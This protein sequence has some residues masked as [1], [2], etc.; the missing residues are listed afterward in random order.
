MTPLTAISPIDGR[1]H[2][3]TKQLS[4][5]FSEEALI[6]Y[7]VKVEVEYFIALCELP[8]PQLKDIDHSVFSYL[9]AIYKNFTIVDAQAVKEIEKTTNHDVKAV[10]YLLKNKFDELGLEESKEFI[11]FGLTSQDI[12]NTAVPLSLKDAIEAEYLPEIEEIIAK[13][14]QLSQDW[15][16]VPLLARTHGQPASPTRLGKE[17]EVFITRLESQLDLLN[18]VP[19]AAKFGGATGNFNAHKIAYP[20]ID[21]KEFGTNFV[22]EKLGLHH[23]FPTTQI[24]HYDH[25]AALFD[26]LKRINNILIDLDRDIWTYVSMDYF[27]QKIKKGEIGSSAMPHKVNPIDFENSEGNLGIANAIFEHLSSKLPISRL[28]RDLT[29]S[30]VLRNIGVP[31]GHTS[32][33]FKSTLKGLG[34]L[35]LNEEK[36]NADLEANWAVVAEAIQTI[37]RREG[38]K[39]P[40]ETLKGLT[41]TNEKINKKSIADFIETLE[42]SEAV[43][44]ELKKITPQNYTGI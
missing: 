2:S 29:D 32:I 39:N 12:N 27:K 26:T 35:L 14:T 7:R 20:N 33:A 18:K 31:M 6:R 37:L 1:Y 5:Y 17:I 21:W 25:M 30:T 43:K 34:K 23:S 8:L 3:K 24:E 10:E 36:L 44:G 42:V 9:R 16:N 19:H 4:A 13:L 22:Q 40:Y 38:F 11:H 28:Q 41:R 15:A